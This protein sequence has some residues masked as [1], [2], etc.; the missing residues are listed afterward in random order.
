MQGSLHDWISAKQP[1]P[2]WQAQ[3]H[4]EH[5]GKAEGE[6]QHTQ[7]RQHEGGSHLAARAQQRAP[8]HPLLALVV[9]PLDGEEHARAEDENLERNKDYRDPID[10][11]ENFQPMT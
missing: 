10:H 5:I 9:M 7:Q 8:V 11:F 6:Q 1:S 3:V 2:S 4:A